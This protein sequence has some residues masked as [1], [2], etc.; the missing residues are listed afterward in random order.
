MGI[1][2]EGKAS[3]EV[4][5]HTAYRLDVH[6]IL[7]RDGTENRPSQRPSLRFRMLPSPLARF[8]AIQNTSLVAHNTTTEVVQ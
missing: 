1:G 8:L 7:E 5:Q 3:G 4:P 6:T 2:V